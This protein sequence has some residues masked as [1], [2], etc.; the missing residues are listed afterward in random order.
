MT[1]HLDDF[2]AALTVLSGNGHIKQR[3]IRAYEDHLVGINDDELP[4]TVQQSFADLRRQ[5]HHV[6]PLN[7]EGAICASVRKMSPDEASE[8]AALVVTLFGAIAR[9]KSA[10]SNSLPPVANDEASVP[11]FLLKSV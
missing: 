2:H 3:L 10:T 9:L 6:A 5:M 8:C 11:P 1:N 7:G 4:V